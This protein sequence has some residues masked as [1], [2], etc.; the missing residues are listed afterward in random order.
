ML[1]LKLLLLHSKFSCLFT[2]ISKMLGL[3]DRDSC[4]SY[5]FSVFFLRGMSVS[6]VLND[7]YIGCWRMCTVVIMGIRQARQH[8]VD[9][10]VDNHYRQLYQIRRAHGDVIS[11]VGT[12]VNTHTHPFSGRL[13]RTT[14]VSRYQKGSNNLDFTEARDSEWQWHQLD[15][16]QVCTSLQTDNHASIPPLVFY[17]PGALLAAQPTASKHWRHSTLLS[18]C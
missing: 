2:L 16:I 4:C 7:M 11:R 9:D 10:T 3:N 12:I 18:T 15:H 5:Y 13:S 1:N 8:P 17:R 14:R 6:S